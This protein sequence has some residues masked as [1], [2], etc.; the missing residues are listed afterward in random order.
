MKDRIKKLL[1][2]GMKPVDIAS[3]VGCSPSYIS[4]L[5]ADEDFKKEVAAL[6][7]SSQEEKD[8]DQH[9]DTRYQNLEHKLVTSLE[10]DLPNA[11]FKE[12]LRALEVVAKRQN[13]RR[14][15]KAPTIAS[16]THQ[17][18]HI[19]NIGLP[20]HALMAPRPVVELNQKNEII[21]IDG[22][23]LA[24]MSS[25]GVKNIFNQIQA[26]KEAAVKVLSEI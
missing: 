6:M 24:P 23:P 7:V 15:Q 5:L 17:S 4:Q 13:E 12:K 26:A 9:L 21:S 22:Q 20:A 25:T 16:P 1:A 14:I 11:D 3:V 2:T 19:T 18:I 8:E 10:Q